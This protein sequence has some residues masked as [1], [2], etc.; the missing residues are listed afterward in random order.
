LETDPA[1]DPQASGESLVARVYAELRRVAAAK[2]RL[3]RG[4]ASL[5][6]T[7]LVHEAWLRLRDQRGLDWENRDQFACLAARAIRRILVDHARARAALKR[8]PP[9]ER[10]S[11]TLELPS[12][13]QAE[14]DVLALDEALARFARHN[15]RAAQVVELRFFAGMTEAEVARALGLGERSVAGDWAYA[16]AWLRRALEPEGRT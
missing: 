8:A 6:T 14:F 4:R 7:D 12:P 3:E 2:L 13:P 5:R 15:E 16:R 1:G 11:L 9:G 10:V